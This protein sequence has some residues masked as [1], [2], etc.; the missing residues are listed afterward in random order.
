MPVMAAT[1]GDIEADINDMYLT[2]FVVETVNVDY[3]DET[4]Q[5]DVEVKSNGGFAGVTYLLEYDT[6]ALTLEEQPVFGDI[7]GFSYEAGPLSDGGHIG[8]ISCADNVYD[9]GILLTYTFRINPEA[10]SDY[11]SVDFV[12]EGTVETANGG[13]QELAVLDE[14]LVAVK[15]D[16]VSG[17][18]VIPGYTVYYDANG[19]SGAPDSQYKSRNDFVTISDTVPEKESHVFLGWAT[20][21]TATVPT[22]KA[23]DKYSADAD[24]TLYAVWKKVAGTIDIKVATVRAE[25]GEEV[26]V[27][28]SLENH[29]GFGGVGFNV[30]YD[31]TR[32]EYVSGEAL[33]AGPTYQ[34]P[35]ANEEL[36]GTFFVAIA[37]GTNVT[38]TGE[39]ISVKFKVLDA[40]EEGLAEISITPE[41]AFKHV[42]GDM[43]DLVVGVTNGGVKIAGEIVGDIN[44]D[45]KVNSDDAVLLY[46][47]FADDAEIE[48]SGSLDFNGDDLE[49]D[50]DAV[51]L[52]RFVLF[53]DLF[54]IDTDA[55][56]APETV[57][58]T[59]T[60]GNATGYTGEEVEVAISLESLAAFKAAGL[61]KFTYD[62]NVFEFEGFAVANDFGDRV[63]VKDASDATFVAASEDEIASFNGEVI[64]ALFT[65]KSDAEPGNYTVSVLP[66]M[67]DSAKF[68]AVSGTVEVKDISEKPVIPV[69]DISLDESELLLGI[70]EYATLVATV[71]PVDASDK[72]VTWESSDTDVATVED[73]VVTAVSKGK[74]KITARTSNGKTATCTVN[75]GV[76]ADAVNFTSLKFTSLAVGKT[77]SFKASAA[78]E[79]GTKPLSTKVV[80]SIVEGG[81]YAEIDEAKGKL[82]ALDFGEVVVRATAEFG[83]ETAYDEV[84]IRICVPATKVTINKTKAAMALGGGDLQL[85]AVMT[86]KE[87]CTD[88][89]AWES[90]DEEIVTVDENGLVSAHA[91]GKAKVTALSGSGKKA[92]CSIT[93]GIPADAVEF[94]SLKSTSLSVGKT[95]TL[96]AKAY[97]T[98][99]EKPVSTNVVYKI[100]EGDESVATIDEKGK[101]KG[102][103][104]GEVV[105]RATAEAG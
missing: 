66:A 99:G 1:E 105:V 28:I 46:K 21:S 101:L 85:E 24:L 7:D 67:S 44:L 72:T 83:T 70:G 42:G 90:S 91:V 37:S 12:T 22:Y 29:P 39:Y 55:V 38:K 97:R 49:N 75:V 3:D 98:D 89:L 69:N 71:S 68:E 84:T 45:E 96:K 36:D 57:K 102:V 86:A 48:Y 9:T 23:G 92:T 82:T 10:K 58:G 88:T 62:E 103:G 60:V 56:A 61:T 13:V 14:N 32:L 40:A 76:R 63:L 104:I 27:A 94:T 43:E 74:A 17:G 15:S 20:E 5:I 30:N 54:P 2:R 33:V 81:E 25:P 4:V 80:Y 78:C 50:K 59:F 52:L 41:E 77:M 19:G 11:Y 65:V 79:D 34:Y 51:R 73:G 95:L 16:S 18:I 47:H 26:D 35:E 64:K 87:E 31:S 53:P 6:E 100:I 93:V 8:M